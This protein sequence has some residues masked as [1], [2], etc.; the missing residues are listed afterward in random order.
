MRNG[1]AG[2][3]EHEDGT[4]GPRYAETLLNAVS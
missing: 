2:V 1:A 3:S 4:V